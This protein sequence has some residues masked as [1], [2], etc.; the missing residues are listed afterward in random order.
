MPLSL[1]AAGKLHPVV[2]GVNATTGISLFELYDLD[3]QNS[4]IANIS[5]RGSVGTGENVRWRVHRRRRSA[6]KFN[7]AARGPTLTDFGVSGS[8]ADPTLELHDGNGHHHRPKDSWKSTQQA[9][10][11]IPAT[12][13]PDA[14]AAIMATYSRNYTAIVRARTTPPAWPWS[15]FT[16]STLTNPLTHKNNR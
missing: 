12:H 16:I 9:A 10:I 13:R 7:R 2:R 1:L 4:K 5:T 3:P 11:Q 8:L 15:K 14:E 6:H